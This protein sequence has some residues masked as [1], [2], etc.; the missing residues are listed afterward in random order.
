MA[1]VMHEINNPLTIIKGR[2]DSGLKKLSQDQFEADLHR[3]YYLSIKES[4]ARI[5]E[6]VKN[7]KS[8]ESRP[9]GTEDL[10]DFSL[11]ESLENVLK[12][13][14]LKSDSRKVDIKLKVEKGV[15]VFGDRSELEKIFFNL[16]SSS[17][18]AIN[19]NVSSWITIESSQDH[20]YSYIHFIDSGKDLSP[21][22]FKDL[23]SVIMESRIII[24][25]HNGHLILQ[26]DS[27]SH[28]IV[29]LPRNNQA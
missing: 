1:D 7:I 20:D 22:E 16:I 29:K 4:T 21:L 2:S 12:A 10:F 23:G 9:T 5:I 8:V 18:D 17:V 24:Q 19:K 14:N 27:S 28:L 13:V 6:L 26:N 25:R 11:H 15:V 3:K